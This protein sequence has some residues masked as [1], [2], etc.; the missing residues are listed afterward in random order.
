MTCLHQRIPQNEEE[1]EIC[2]GQ[3]RLPV[4]DSI[5]CLYSDFF[6]PDIMATPNSQERELQRYLQELR[7]PMLL[8]GKPNNP[9]KWWEMNEHR[10]PTLVL[11]ARKYLMMMTSSASV[12]RMFS[13]AGWIVDKR[14][15]SLL[16]S[17]AENR[18]LFVAN[19]HCLVCALFFFVRA[20][21]GNQL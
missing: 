11:L 13:W 18:L 5:E 10:F 17:T 3:V 9:L 15:C 2:S 1:E 12:E 7:I 14:R 16:D 6:G 21:L 20:F 4:V 19:K 8:E